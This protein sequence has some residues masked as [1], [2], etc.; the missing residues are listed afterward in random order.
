MVDV[1]LTNL[2]N[3]RE[4]VRSLDL[5]AFYALGSDGGR[6]PRMRTESLSSGAERVLAGFTYLTRS[7]V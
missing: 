4:G 6:S 3:L 7:V 1:S 5:A 2:L